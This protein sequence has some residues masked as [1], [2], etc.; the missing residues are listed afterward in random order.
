MSD[1]KKSQSTTNQVF[2]DNNKGLQPTSSGT[3]MP[4][5]KPA[6]TTGQTQQSTT[7]AKKDG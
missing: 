1:N 4:K 6:N 3:P 2:I 7:R 5:V